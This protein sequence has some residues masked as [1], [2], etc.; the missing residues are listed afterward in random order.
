MVRAR[1]CDCGRGQD[2]VIAAITRM[3]SAAALARYL[4]GPGRHNEHRY[5]GRPG[6]AVIAGTACARAVLDGTTWAK[7]FHRTS[8]GADSHR[9]RRPIWHCSLR[10]APTDRAMDD[11]EWRTIAQEFVEALG[12]EALPWVAIRHGDDHVHLAVCRVGDDGR[13]WAGQ[14][15]RRLAQQACVAIEQTHHLF[16]A[17]RLRSRSRRSADSQIRSGEHRKALRTGTTPQRVVLAEKVIAIAQAATGRGRDAFEAECARLG[18]IA[19]ANVA[20]STGR[21]SGYNFSD[22]TVAA[23]DRLTFKAS[24]LHKQLGWNQLG[25]ILEAVAG[26]RS[27]PPTDERAYLAA[28]QRLTEYGQTWAGRRIPDGKSELAAGVQPAESAGAQLSFEAGIAE[29]VVTAHAIRPTAGRQQPRSQSSTK[30]RAG[31]PDGL[32]R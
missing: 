31:R 32:A 30:P 3:G 19:I 10:A 8:A 24:Q 22:A 6:G 7:D 5:Q 9:V 13:V 29:A 1:S 15:D 12:I 11:A 18:I 27:G 23:E 4:H 28:R 2:P 21:M 26:S 14:H 20:A 17:P 16:Q 25:P